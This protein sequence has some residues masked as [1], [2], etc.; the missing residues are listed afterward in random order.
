MRVVLIGPSYPFRGG[1]SHYTTLLYR[2]LRRRHEVRFL[3]LR[4]QYPRW[5]YPGR[6]DRDESAFA[7]REEGSE[8]LLDPLN[9]ISW[10][11]TADA[12]SAFR[13]QLLILP[14]WASFWAPCYIAIAT[15]V[16]RT[17][18]CPVLYLC[19]NVVGHDAKRHDRW[20]AHRALSC[21]DLFIVHSAQDERYL[22]TLFP[23]ATVRRALHPTYDVFRQGGLPK[24]EAKRRLGA[25]TDLV[26]FFGFVRPYKGLG[27]LLDAMP[28]VLASRDVQLWVVG[29]IWEGADKYRARIRELGL[30]GHVHLVDRY[31]PNEEVSLYFTAADAVVLPYISGTGSGVAQIALAHERPLV[32]TTVGDLAEVVEEGRTGY[33]VPPGDP[34]ALAQAILR[35]YEQPGDYWAK[36]IRDRMD[37]FAWEH[38]VE[39]IEELAE[40]RN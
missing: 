37:R 36:N 15:W 14:W 19:H 22:R 10:W 13:P 33:L 24:E 9:P 23:R 17:V 39:R 12:A 26:L 8:A 21:G 16:K 7:I 27:H 11:R 28:R 18:G 3:S 2:H 31:V 30:E 1:I 35:I 34:A 20:L 32:A 29:E 6:S 40:E 38:L 5:L 4:R 25:R